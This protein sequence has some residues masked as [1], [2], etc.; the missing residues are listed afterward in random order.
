MVAAIAGEGFLRDRLELNDPRG[1]RERPQLVRSEAERRGEH[2]RDRLAG[3]MSGACS[4]E[5]EEE[6]LV[7]AEGERRD[8]ERACALAEEAS[9]G[10][11]K[12]PDMV[13]GVVADCCDEERDCRGSDRPAYSWCLR[14]P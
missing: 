3:E 14:W 10:G 1:L 4:D 2:D 7:R 13:P 5:H 9:V 8:R 12:R 6:E 11:A